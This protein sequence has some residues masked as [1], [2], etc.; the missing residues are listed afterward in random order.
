MAI[1][2]ILVSCLKPMPPNLNISKQTKFYLPRCPVLST[3]HD[4]V[5]CWKATYGGD[6]CLLFEV[7][8]SECCVRPLF[9][10][11]LGFRC[12]KHHIQPSTETQL[13]QAKPRDSKSAVPKWT[14]E[15]G[16][17]TRQHQFPASVAFS[18]QTLRVHF[19]INTQNIR[20]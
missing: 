10:T 6:G 19:A 12:L 5:G 17:E 4:R 1:R 8:C 16:N 18:R 3:R 9:F 2:C 11:N 13:R 15:T 20:G 7:E 14:W